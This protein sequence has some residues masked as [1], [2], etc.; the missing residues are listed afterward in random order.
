MALRIIAGEAKGCRLHI[1]QG[2][3]VRPSTSRVRE[4]VFNSLHS[5]DLLHD[6]H[7]LD[8][9][10]GSGA[11]GLEALSRG[12]AS[13]TFVESAPSALDALR[14]NVAVTGLAQRSHVVPGDVMVKLQRLTGPAASGFD[15]G[16]GQFDVA[17]CDPPY[18]FTMWTDL[19]AQLSSRVV[20]VESVS[21][22]QPGPAWEVVK[23]QRY[24]GTVVV[25]AK[26]R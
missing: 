4:A 12:A 19:L 23:S 16:A 9:Y 11:L 17:L 5:L 1:P 13:A 7:V 6:A 21:E 22:V 15:A 8:L 14:A 24:A 25:I 26:Q 10:A 3:Q 20:V 2:T 18:S